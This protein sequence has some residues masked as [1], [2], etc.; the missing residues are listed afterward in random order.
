MRSVLIRARGKR[1]RYA[2][3]TAETAP[4]APTAIW[5]G[6]AKNMKK[7]PPIMPPNKYTIRNLNSPTSLRR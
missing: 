1:R 3:S 2:P 5:K 6:S 7:I 4:D